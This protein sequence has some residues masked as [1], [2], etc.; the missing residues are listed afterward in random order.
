MR[1]ESNEM[2]ALSN[3]EHGRNLGIFILD[4]LVDVHVSL[5]KCIIQMCD[6]E[7]HYLR[8]LCQS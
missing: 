8:V 1:V 7:I 4:I 6:F 5:A 2:E 3:N